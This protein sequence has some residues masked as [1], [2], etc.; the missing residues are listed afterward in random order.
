MT[1][2]AFV[3][4]SGLLICDITKSTS[5]VSQMSIYNALLTNAR[6]CYLIL[7][8]SPRCFWLLVVN[9]R[10]ALMS[11]LSF[12][13]LGQGLLFLWD[14]CVF[15]AW[16][17]FAF[18]SFTAVA[19]SYLEI[20][21]GENWECPWLGVF[22]WL[23]LFPVHPSSFVVQLWTARTVLK[24]QVEPWNSACFLAGPDPTSE[25]GAFAPTTLDSIC[26]LK[27]E[28]P[29]DKF[30]EKDRWNIWMQWWMQCLIISF[31]Y[32]HY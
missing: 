8:W 9:L 14:S 23:W 1:Y 22:F 20:S 16:A 26:G 24:T 13:S 28:E 17:L 6:Q 27:G 4:S 3:R 21:S 7:L 25:D 29:E 30:I 2:S 15:P 32:Y 31:I 19:S 18:W 5:W 11:P 10:E 12:I